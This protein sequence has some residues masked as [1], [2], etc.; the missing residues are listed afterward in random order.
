[1]SMYANISY[2]G[3][4][5]VFDPGLTKLSSKGRLQCYSE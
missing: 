4:I 3:S 2:L 1:M 5:K